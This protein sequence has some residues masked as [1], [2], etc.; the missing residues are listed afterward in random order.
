[1]LQALIRK[2][3]RCV[4]F[5]A[6]H[7]SFVHKNKAL[8]GVTDLLR[9]A[10]YPNYV[11]AKPEPVRTKSDVKV[12]HKV[13]GTARGALVDRQV[14]SWADGK[15]PKRMHPWA[16]YVIQALLRK[17]L[18]P[19][20]G[21]VPCVDLEARIGTA[22]DLVCV[23]SAKRL[24]V[25]ELKSGYAKGTHDASTGALLGAP[26]QHFTDCPKN[27]HFLQLAATLSL[28]E[29]TYCRHARGVLVRVDDAGVL[30]KWLPEEFVFRTGDIRYGASLRYSNFDE[31]CAA[32]A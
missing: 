28:F 22:A 15:P 18:T 19:L 2:H 31:A 32:S 27:Q 9:L 1:M 3:K 16:S 13:F 5:S 4:P 10:Y 30:L 14:A 23:D 26:F 7:K 29:S 25:V 20:A 17:N 21:Q 8:A 6:Q 12:K 24:V 11:K